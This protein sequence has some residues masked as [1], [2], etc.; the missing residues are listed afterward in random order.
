MPALRES[1][2]EIAARQTG[3]DRDA[4]LADTPFFELGM[5]SLTVLEVGFHIEQEFGLDFED[6]MTAQNMPRTLTDLAAL[7]RSH[8]ERKG[9]Q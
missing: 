8:L 5:D 7:V 1:L 3:A 9:A 2:A 6:Q 4:L